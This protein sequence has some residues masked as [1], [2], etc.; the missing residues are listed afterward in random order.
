M[1]DPKAFA[2]VP[3]GETLL[4]PLLNASYP[5]LRVTLGLAAE[6]HGVDGSALGKNAWNRPFTIPA[7]TPF[8]LTSAQRR[9]L[10]ITPTQSQKGMTYNA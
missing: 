7:N 6:V 5:V 3:A 8:D 1:T 9:N 4:I 2:T 10:L